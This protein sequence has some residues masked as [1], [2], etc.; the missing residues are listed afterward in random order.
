MNVNTFIMR[1]IGYNYV[2]IISSIIFFFLFCL[3]G[4]NCALNVD[5]YSAGILDFFF[6]FIIFFCM[7]SQF[8]FDLDQGTDA[9]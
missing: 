1:N 5:S 2:V 4:I 3:Y 8:T 6:F 7:N 9:S